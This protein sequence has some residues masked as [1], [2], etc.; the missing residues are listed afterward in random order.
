MRINKQI[1]LKKI[2][3]SL[4]ICVSCLIAVW[5]FLMTQ[6]THTQ[7]IVD[8]KR[9]NEMANK[10]KDQRQMFWKVSSTK[11][12]SDDGNRIIAVRRIKLQFEDTDPK[13]KSFTNHKDLVEIEVFSKTEIPVTNAAQYLIIGDKAFP[14]PA[15]SADLHSVFVHLSPEEFNEIKEGA[16]VSY[17]ISSA[18]VD[19]EALRNA[20]KNGEPGELSGAKFGRLYKTMIEQSSA[21]EEDVKAQKLRIS[22]ARNG[23]Q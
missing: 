8:E 16:I 11:N 1:I 12:P 20:Y 4:A 2:G 19:K 15:R 6:K 17:M 22:K 14:E 13:G 3:L 23:I 18:L 5:F 10:A 21:I 7:T 9:Q